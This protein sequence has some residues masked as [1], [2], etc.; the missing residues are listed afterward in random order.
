[1]KKK[2]KCNSHIRILQ[3]IWAQYQKTRSLA[4]RRSPGR[5]KKGSPRM[6]HSFIIKAT[7][8]RL[9]A[10]ANIAKM[11]RQ[12]HGVSVSR[13]TVTGILWRHGLSVTLLQRGPSWPRPRNWRGSS[14]REHTQIGPWMIGA[15]GCGPMRRCAGR[16]A[17]ERGSMSPVEAGSATRL[18]A[19]ARRR[20]MACK[21]T[22]GGPWGR[23]GLALSE[24]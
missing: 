4:P 18:F 13:R 21:F 20:N 23:M 10:I 15:R 11:L 2:H 5:P 8:N 3:R 7:S 16:L 12:V 22:H 6:E 17:I 14:G 24:R 19:F 9:E 1:M